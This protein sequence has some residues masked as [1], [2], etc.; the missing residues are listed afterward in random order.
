MPL[1]SKKCPFFCNPNVIF[2][3]VN[4]D[5]IPDIKSV[6]LD[7]DVFKSYIN[8]MMATQY[9]VNLEKSPNAC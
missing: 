4:V 1:I 2:P 3:S 5:K 7:M 6:H 8:T 9:N